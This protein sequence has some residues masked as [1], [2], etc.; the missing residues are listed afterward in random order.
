MIMMMS[1]LASATSRMIKMIE[2]S[3]YLSISISIIV[4]MM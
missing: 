2:E 4:A 3:I 1:I